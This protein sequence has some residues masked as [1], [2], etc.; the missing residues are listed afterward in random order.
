MK[1]EV[2]KS[3]KKCTKVEDINV[4]SC[5]LNPIIYTNVRNVKRL[6]A[7]DSTSRMLLTFSRTCIPNMG[8]LKSMKVLVQ[9]LAAELCHV[10]IVLLFSTSIFS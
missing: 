2:R 8:K 6:A 9:I 10:F 5:V 7:F 1:S 3:K 4:F